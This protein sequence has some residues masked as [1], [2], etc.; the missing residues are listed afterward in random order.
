MH[1]LIDSNCARYKDGHLSK[2]IRNRRLH[3]AETSTFQP[4]ATVSLRHVPVSRQKRFRAKTLGSLF[5]RRSAGTIT[6][7]TVDIGVRTPLL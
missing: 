4:I 7:I 2:P 6:T 5:R 3:P 1:H